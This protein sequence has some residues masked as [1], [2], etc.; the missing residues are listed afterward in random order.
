MKYSP[1]QVE[2]KWQEKWENSKIFNMDNKTDKKKFYSLVMFPYPSGDKLHVGHWYNYAPAD[3]YSRYVRMKGYNVFEPIGFDSFGLPAE[4]YAI[5]TNV[6]PEDSIKKNVE[7]MIKQLKRIGTMYDFNHVIATSNPDYYKWTQW[8]FRELYKNGLAY[9]KK[10]YVNW[11]NSCNTV[12]AN[13]QV[14]DGF[15]ER[16]ESEVVQKDLEQWFFKITKYSEELLNHE[17]LDWPSKTVL[18]QKN[19]IGKSIGTEFKFKVENSDDEISVY[20]TRV[21]TVFGVTYVT[22]SPEHPLV[23]KIVTEDKKEEVLKYQEK[24]R[25][26][27]EIERLSDAKEKTGVFTGKYAI[28]PFTNEKVPIWISD[29]VLMHYGTGA[30]MAVPAHDERDH[31][32]AL[33]FNLEIKEVIKNDDKDVDILKEAM[34]DY[35]YLVNSGKY[36]NLKSEDAILKMIEDLE[37]EKKGFKK[38]NFRLHDWLISRQRYWGAPIPIVYC[39][40]CG[41]VLVEEEDLPV[42]LPRDVDFKPT[43]ESPLAA[44][45]SFVNTTC[46]KCGKKARRETDTMDTFVCSSWYYLRYPDNKIDDK[47]FNKELVD[48][49]LPVDCYIGGPEHACMHLLYA[50]FVTKALYDL[51]HI[52]FKEPFS[53][54][55]HQGMI[56]SNGEKMSKSRGNVV[57]PDEFIDRVGSDVFR[58]YLMFLGPFEDGGDWSD[59]G[60]V[61]VERFINRLYQYIV[62]YKDNYDEKSIVYRTA[63]HKAIKR[64]ID[65]IENF[66]FNTAIAILMETLNELRA[67]NSKPSK[68][69]LEILVKLI[70]PLAPHF[71]EEMWEMLGNSYSVFDQEYPTFVEEWTKDQEVEFVISI[72]GKVKDK[73]KVSPD[74]EKDEALKQAKEL[75]KIKVLIENKTIVKEIF[76]KGKLINLV[77]K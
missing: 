29:Y 75:E 58:L 26:L 70:A 36:N 2:K 53:K 25:L 31:E 62:D 35:G 14:K 21:D 73:M 51:G 67:T 23:L 56:L 11:C 76:V 33:K 42:L 13:E 61:G 64:C 40:D 4:N 12:L 63:I 9:K 69:D 20:T 39:D 27:T 46:P 57:S 48:K 22:L 72:N 28:N 7:V 16:C 66:R 6:H 44:C 24:T 77:I 47:P 10:A 49:W 60:I 32:F 38:V 43:G 3:S 37:N 8:L 18:M 54:L 5:K 68:V 19:W 1:N 50:R 59:K 15:C 74:I 45:S 17:S 65:S 55:V 71:G 34:T 30:V 52:N 41:E